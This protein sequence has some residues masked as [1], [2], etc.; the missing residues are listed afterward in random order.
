[1][2]TRGRGVSFKK[3]WLSKFNKTRKR[4]AVTFS[5]NPRQ[6]SQ[7]NLAKTPR[8]PLPLISNYC[9]SMEETSRLFCCVTSFKFCQLRNPFSKCSSKVRENRIEIIDLKLEMEDLFHLLLSKPSNCCSGCCQDN[10][11]LFLDKL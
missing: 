3:I 10:F 6:P 11:V 8:T 5:D 2:H 7:T 9:A 1:M 4:G